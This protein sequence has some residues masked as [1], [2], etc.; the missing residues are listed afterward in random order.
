MAEGNVS[1]LCTPR[2]VNSSQQVP[3]FLC[4][5]QKAVQKEQLQLAWLRSEVLQ[6]SGPGSWFL[7]QGY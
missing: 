5:L 4:T 7:G 2:R 3:C 1:S 6:G